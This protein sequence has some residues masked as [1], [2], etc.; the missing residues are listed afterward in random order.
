M[1][2][3]RNED[4]GRPEPKCEDA[5]PP[6]RLR[7][8]PEKGNPAGREPGRALIHEQRD[9]AVLLEHAGHAAYGVPIP[10][11][12]DTESS[13][14]A[15]EIAVEERILHLAGHGVH[16]KSPRGEIVARQLPVAEVSRHQNHTATAAQGTIDQMPFGWIVHQ[17]QD[18][19]AVIARQHRRL[20]GRA[21]EVLV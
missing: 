11:G 21:P 16:A 13:A 1:L 4:D 15:I 14:G 8:P 7:H 9:R 5:W 6:G 20:D 12:L 17:L 3:H 19:A 18:L 10:D 2:A